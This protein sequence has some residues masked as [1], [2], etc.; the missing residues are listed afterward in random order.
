MPDSDLMTA[1]KKIKSS[2]A[3]EQFRD[4]V[5]DAQRGISH[6]ITRNEKSVAALVPTDVAFLAPIVKA[7]LSE[8]GKS[9][10]VSDDARIIAAVK[11]ALDDVA[12]G[13]T[14]TYE[15]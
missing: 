15:V 7:V 1:P 9:L 5:D 10:K 4:L 12:R 3:R 14:K 13:R 8:L 11:T 2:D 6:I